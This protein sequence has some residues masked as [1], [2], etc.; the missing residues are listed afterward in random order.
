MS[1]LHAEFGHLVAPGVGHY[2]VTEA[3]RST[4]IDA[5]TGEQ[6]AV[7]TAATDPAHTAAANRIATELTVKARAATEATR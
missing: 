6:V 5:R 1:D 7:V 2:V 3:G 4:V